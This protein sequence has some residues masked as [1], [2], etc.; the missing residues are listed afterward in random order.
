MKSFIERQKQRLGQAA[1]LGAENRSGRLDTLLDE[2][3]RDA[4]S[5]LARI[6]AIDDR[7]K[8]A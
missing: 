8:Q 4:D 6:G 1:R 2:T 3:D 5:M 7:F